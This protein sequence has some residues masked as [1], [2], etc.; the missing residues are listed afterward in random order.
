MDDFYK[1]LILLFIAVMTGGGVTHLIKE[2]S[3]QSWIGGYR[4]RFGMKSV[5]TGQDLDGDG[6]NDVEQKFELGVTKLGRP[7]PGYEVKI[8]K[9]NDGDEQNDSN[10]K[11]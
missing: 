9:D 11:L 2:S 5:D 6:K 4:I 7:P 8:D 3:C 1:Q 10:N